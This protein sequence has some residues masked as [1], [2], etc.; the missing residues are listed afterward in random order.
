VPRTAIALGAALACAA[1]LAA[2]A[3]AGPAPLAPLPGWPRWIESADGRT[4]NQ[5][6]GLTFVGRNPNGSPVFLAADDEGALW[7][8][9]VGEAAGTI[10]LDPI[11]FDRAAQETLARFPKKDL[12]GIAYCPIS[13]RVL[14][15]IEGNTPRD[16]APGDSAAR[17]ARA[18]SAAGADF[19]KSLGVYVAILDPSDPLLAE[20]VMGIE[21][22]PLPQWDAACRLATPNR[23]FEGIAVREDSILLGLEG[24]L[25][26]E[27]GFA[28]STMIEVFDVGERTRRE[29]STKP[30]GLVTVCGLEVGPNGR[31]YGIDRN[32]GVLF[33]FRIA[34]SGIADF[35]STPLA[36]PG[37]RGVAYTV[38][39]PEAI[40]LD[41][42]GG[43]WIAIDPW[44][45]EPATTAGLT[46]HDLQNYKKKVPL[47]YKFRDPFVARAGD[48]PSPGP[49]PR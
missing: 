34:E 21:R 7:R 12:E 48:G 23:G 37:V 28:D 25:V 41:D 19:R 10:R 36:F 17:R 18:A 9:T 6:S 43:V 35:R 27:E 16:D 4:T 24:I 31:W 47:L 32:Q 33:S 42:S 44:I 15:S 2:A 14:V 20:R 46:P 38:P 13:M 3:H 45:Y 1:G 26:G 49:S 8:L 22:F 11:P 30:L 39:A 5:T 40:A 29:F